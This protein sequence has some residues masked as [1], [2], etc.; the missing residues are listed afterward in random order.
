MTMLQ[1]ETELAKNTRNN[2]RRTGAKL[3]SA[4]FLSLTVRN[5]RCF[6]LRQTLDLSNGNGKPRQ[7]TIILGD[8]GTGKTTL[9]QSL[10]AM[11]PMTVV[12]MN[13]E[14]VFPKLYVDTQLY[15]DWHI[16]RYGSAP[17]DYHLL[18]VSFALGKKIL[19]NPQNSSSIFKFHVEGKYADWEATHLD[20]EAVSEFACFAYGASRH[21]VP[22]SLSQK[23][24]K[25]PYA[26]LFNE[27]ISLRNAEEW[28]LQTDYGSSKPSP[29]QHQMIEQLDKVKKVLLEI[30]P[31]VKDIRI[32]Q[33]GRMTLPTVEFQTD[34]GWVSIND[35]GLGYRTL[36]A[37]MVDFAAR[38][39]ERYPGSEN[40]LEEPAVVL[41]DEI[42]L[43][44]HPKWQ[45]DLIDY[46]T[47]LFPN[48]QFIVT[49]HSPLIVQA[50]AAKDANIVV[51]RRE[52]DHV[53]IDNSPEAV[54]GWRADQILISDLFDLPSARSKEDEELLNKRQTILSKTKLTAKDRK[55]LKEIEAKMSSL[56]VMEDPKYDKAM[57]IIMRA[58]EKLEKEK[59]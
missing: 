54:R 16:Y 8:N 34:Y 35:L 12:S 39:F 29:Q 44:L 52:G 9:L 23:D 10:V 20:K 21:I 33:Y 55:D 36:I 18:S 7:W 56:P 4:Y 1:I 30:L 31:G 28:L 27:H 17:T 6:G 32:A 42:D 49:T 43:H 58:A 5:V 59:K 15:L 37:W 47:N 50:A 19:T 53:V 51:C 24:A 57:D 40:P 3:K 11:L 2:N 25:K 22:S 13:R 26:G 46:L 38:M 14:E 45:R 41:V 48:T